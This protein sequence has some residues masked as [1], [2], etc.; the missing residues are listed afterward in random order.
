MKPTIIALLLASS[1]MFAADSA[2]AQDP[3]HYTCYR[4][5]APITVDGTLDEPS[6]QSAPRTDLF[7]DIEGDVKPAPRFQTRAMMLWDDTYFYVAVDMEEPDV[8]ATFTER[9]TYDLWFD[10]DF[11]V[12]IDPNGDADEYYELEINA[13][14]TV[15]DLFLHRVDGVRQRDTAWDIEGLEHAVHIYGTLNQPGDVDQGWSVEIAFPWEV[16]AEW[17]HTPAPPNDEDCWRV[18]FS[19]VEYPFAVVDGKYETT[20]VPDNWVWSPQGEIAMHIPQMWGYVHFPT[21]HLTTVEQGAGPAPVPE[22]YALS[23]NVPNPFNPVTLI[24]YQV[25]QASHVTVSIY[26]IAGQQIATLASGTREAGAHT[27]R[28]NGTAFAS[29]LYFCRLQAEGF[30][31]TRRMVLLR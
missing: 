13:L 16:L 4:A 24:R 8:W 30:S 14:N 27:V 17:A 10:N 12:F 21:E 15:W 20:G 18:N 29:G 31:E 6:W 11:E 22:W 1:L 19:R 25:P 28:W 26:N 9:D 23:Q 3:K 5:L 7:V 2:S